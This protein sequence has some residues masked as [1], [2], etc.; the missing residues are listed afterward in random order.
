MVPMAPFELSKLVSRFPADIAGNFQTGGPQCQLSNVAARTIRKNNNP[1][2]GFL[3]PA[4]WNPQPKLPVRRRSQGNKVIDALAARLKR[5]TLANPKV[6]KALEK[7]IARTGHEINDEMRTTSRPTPTVPTP[8]ALDV[9]LAAVV[10]GSIGDEDLSHDEFDAG[11]MPSQSRDRGND[12]TDAELAAALFDDDDGSD[13]GD[14]DFEEYYSPSSSSSTSGSPYKGKAVDPGERSTP[15]LSATTFHD[16][17][18][19]SGDEVRCP[20]IFHFHRSESM[21]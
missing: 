6:R 5:T 8:A 3:R 16:D 1:S 7:R 12:E 11:S 4:T 18:G 19:S 15:K 20:F 17:A 13:D 9:G 14:D 10:N 2:R 21:F